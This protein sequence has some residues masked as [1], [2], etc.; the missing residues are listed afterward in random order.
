MFYTLLIDFESLECK[1]M[2]RFDTEAVAAL[3]C[4]HWW[5]TGKVQL[6]MV[7]H[8]NIKYIPV[9]YVLQMGHWLHLAPPSRRPCT[10]AIYI[11][12]YEEHSITFEP[13]YLPV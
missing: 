13:K 11:Y 9:H 3:A 5:G 2:I 6:F 8:T 1:V 4:R 10:E 7:G 12:I